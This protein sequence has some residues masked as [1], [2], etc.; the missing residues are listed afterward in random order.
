LHRYKFRQP[1]W[2]LTLLTLVLVAL[3][4]A[5]GFWQLARSDAKAQLLARF[6]A[7]R[8]LPVLQLNQADLA[9]E[10]LHFRTAVVS[11]VFRETPALM[12]NNRI[13]QGR[14]GFHHL[15]L[16][17]LDASATYLL[18]NR[19]WV[20]ATDDGRPMLEGLA[21]HVDGQTLQGLLV[22][23]PQ[24][25]LRL[26]EPRLHADTQVLE[27]PYLDPHG[28]GQMLNVDLLPV[29]LLL[30]EGVIEQYQRQR[31]AVWLNPQRHQGYALQWFSLALLLAII[32]L[33]TN[34]KRSESH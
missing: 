18:V 8:M 15:S 12:L 11:G 2:Y 22:P 9:T 10:P 34:L 33:V 4:V 7:N 6:D 24:T 14:I 5:L 23:V 31:Q 30:D 25:G 21:G 32:Y 29:M 19:G 16:L 3:L 27:L 17:R 13:R 26:G 28:L 1:A 20:P